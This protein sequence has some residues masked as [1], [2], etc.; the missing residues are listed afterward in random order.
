MA[1]EK[2]KSFRVKGLMCPPCTPFTESGEV[3]YD[4][5]DKYVQHHVDFGVLNVFLTGT[6]GEGNSLTVEERKKVV[7]AWIAAGRGRLSAILVHV[8]AGNIKDSQDLAKHAQAV[9]ADGIACV[10]PTYH[11]PQ[12]LEDYVNYMQQVAA[13]A[14]ELPFYLYDIDFVTGVVYS[15]DDFFT[16]AKERI[17]TLRGLKHTSPSFPSMNTLLLKHPGYEVFLGSDEIYLESLA[18]GM[19]ITI[20]TSFLGHVHNRLKAAFDRGDMQTA[21]LEQNRALEVCLIRRKHGLSFPGGAKALLRAMGL[22]VGSPRLP[23]SPISD[24]AVAAIKADLEKI[25][26]F[27]WILKEPKE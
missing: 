7:E 26:F 13:A 9:G 25:G 15:M 14:P 20:G 6:T 17:P 24:A 4:V 2:V 12:T 16:L 5:I 22:D 18:L 10:C 1:S 21:R 8:G 11:K 23:L 3:N 19:D 27:N